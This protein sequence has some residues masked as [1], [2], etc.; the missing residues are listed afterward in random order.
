MA[1]NKKAAALAAFESIGAAGLLGW[2]HGRKGQMPEKYKVPLDGGVG[3][4][5]VLAGIFG[6]GNKYLKMVAPHALAVGTGA[7]SYFFGSLG[8]QF[9]Q[10]ARF[11]AGEMKSPYPGPYLTGNENDP[12]KDWR[13]NRTITAG[14]PVAGP[15]NGQQYARAWR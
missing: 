2:V 8:G 4:A 14:M 5:L 7:L 13:N 12:N 9:G 11:K 10:K 1:E 15:V 6:S 3:A